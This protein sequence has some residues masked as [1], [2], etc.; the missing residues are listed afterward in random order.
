[1]ITSS[2]HALSNVELT[3][4][5]LTVEPNHE[6][7]VALQLRRKGL[8]AYVPIRRERRKWSDRIKEVER[9][10]FPGYVFSHFKYSDCMRILNLPGVRAIVSR[11]RYPFPIGEAEIAG[12]RA[13]T[14]AGRP[15][16]SL[17]SVYKGQQIVITRGPLASWQGVVVRLKDVWHVVVS[18]EALGCAVAVEVDADALGEIPSPL[19]P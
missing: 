9:V 11:G 18:I 16:V 4:F 15:I 7:T 8:E 17:P 6:R 10:L 1:V 5:A 2:Q 19:P 12:V 14:E 13:L 3:W